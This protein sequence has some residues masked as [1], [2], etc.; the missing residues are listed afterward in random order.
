MMGPWDWIASER[1]ASRPLL[2]LLACS[3][4][5]VHC[6]IACGDAGKPGAAPEAVPDAA[7]SG[8]GGLDSSTSGGDDVS[9]GGDSAGPGPDGAVGAPEASIGEAGGAPSCSAAQVGPDGDFKGYRMFPADHPINTPIDTL[10][11][12]AHSADW[13]AN[14][15]SAHAYLQIDLSMPYNVVAANTPPVTATTLDY[16]SKPYPN[17]WPFPASAVIEQGD[18]HCLAFDVG[19]CKLYEVYSFVW[20]S[21]MTAFTGGSGTVWDTTIDDPGNGSGSD[22]AGL[23]ITPLLIRYDELIGAGA[24]NHALRFT[25]A[26]TEQGHIAPARASASSS[27]GSGIPADPHDPTFPPMGMRVRLKASYDP[28]AHS[29][30]APIVA[31]LKAIQKYGLLL[32]DNGSKGSPMY[33]TGASDNALSNALSGPS[34]LIKQITTADLEVADTGAVTQ[35]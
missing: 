31:L 22:A 19:T 18:G 25:C 29:F 12:S 2:R 33:I 21:G 14:C 17:P 13:L 24:I 8:G 4:L 7:S 35:D 32:A 1:R 6:A 5:L 15:S 11:V 30:P 27:A 16:N 26:S 28:T 3:S 9:S 10:P 34:S 20:G 23:P